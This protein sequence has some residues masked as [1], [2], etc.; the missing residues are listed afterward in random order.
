MKNQV[1]AIRVYLEE[2][3]HVLNSSL[4]KSRDAQV[5]RMYHFWINRAVVCLRIFDK[6]EMSIFLKM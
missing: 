3:A 6:R 5:K 1:D 4:T 2:C